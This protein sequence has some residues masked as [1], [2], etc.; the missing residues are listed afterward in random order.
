MLRSLKDLRNYQIHATDGE[1][2]RVSDVLFDDRHWRV[3]YFV[4][5]TGG[6][7]GGREVLL[8]PASVREAVWPDRAIRVALTRQ[9]V[10]DSPGSETALPVS[11]QVESQLVNYYGWPPY[12]G[13]T[14]LGVPAMV[15]PPPP[16]KEVAAAA[17]QQQRQQQQAPPDPN[18]RSLHEVSGY[19]IAARDDSIGHLDDLIAD[20]EN[21][22]IRYL[23]IDTRNWLPGRKVILAPVW[24][25][26]INWAERE[27]VVDLT[28]EQIKNS[29]QYD[30]ATP[31]NRGY[32]ARLY[33]YYGRP[34]YW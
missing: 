4:V 34:A 19:H 28:K 17:E 18:L 32:E 26:S 27:V 31:V 21:W 9:Q 25:R 13:A 20:D 11:R 7:L 8:S 24:A 16:P 3:R 30:P 1:L 5:E 22:T 10:K 14:E 33:D 23:V 2:G 29:P 6:W 12:W 15:P